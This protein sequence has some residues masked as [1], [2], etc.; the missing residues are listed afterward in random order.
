MAPSADLGVS[1]RSRA[2]TPSGGESFSRPARPSRPAR[3]GGGD[4]AG[5]PGRRTPPRQAAAASGGNLPRGA[6]PDRCA[7]PPLRAGG[8]AG[9]GLEVEERWDRGC[10]DHSPPRW[11]GRCWGALE[12]S[13]LVRGH[14]GGEGGGAGEEGCAEGI[15]EPPSG[16]Q[17]RAGEA[18]GLY[19]VTML[20]EWGRAPGSWSFF[21]REAEVLA[22]RSVGRE[23]RELARRAA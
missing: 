7:Q 20:P 6:G 9:A 13:R 8:E 23:L 4:A 22:Q 3:R 2:P 14:W 16:A 21:P 5:E 15:W 1:T 19:R 11:L 17:P 18:T 12:V 10:A